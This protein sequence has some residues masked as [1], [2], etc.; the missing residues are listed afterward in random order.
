MIVLFLI[1]N[2]ELEEKLVVM[3]EPD[4]IMPTKVSRPGCEETNSCY[5]PS[6]VTIKIGDQVT[7]SN[8]DSAF[9]S[10][11]SG[12]YGEPSSLFDSGYL[13]PGQQFS[14]TFKDEG[15]VDYFCTLHP[16]MKGQVL[17]E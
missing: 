14:F 3:M 8:E 10:V 12:F 17:V 9:H 5:I 11:T 13:D 4:V 15:L 2:S 7:W 16:W 1:N 6:L